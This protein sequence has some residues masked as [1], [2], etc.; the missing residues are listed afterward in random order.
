[1]KHGVAFS[2]SIRTEKIKHYRFPDGKES[3]MRGKVLL[4][5]L[6]IVSCIIFLKIVSLQLVRG[7]YYRTLSD[8]NR[9]RTKIIYAP[10]GVLFDR[11]NIPLVYNLP[12]FRVTKGNKTEVMSREKALEQISQ[13]AQNI[14][15]DSLRQYPFKDI[16]SHVLGYVGQITQEE[17]E[18]SDFN[19]YQT[20][21]LIGKS[22]IEY[23]YEKLLRGTNGKQLL[24]VDATGKEVRVL[25]QTDPISGQD[26]HLTLDSKLQQ[27]AYNAMKDVSRGALIISTPKGEILSIIS[28]PSF[29]PNLFTL[30]SSYTATNTAYPSISGI[31]TGVD[32][33]LLDRAISGTYPPGSTFKVVMAAGALQSKK[34]DTSYEVDDQGKIQIGPYTYSN[35]YYTDYGKT[36]GKI[37]VV[38]A[39]TR[40][41]DIFFYELAAKM[42]LSTLVSSARQMGVGKALGID[43]PGEAHGV[44]P[45]EAWKKKN[46]GEDWYLG[47][48][49]IYGIG[50]GYLLTT[51]L[52]VNAWTQIIAN[53]GDLYQPH[54]LENMGDRII[55]NNVLSSGTV[56]SVRKGMIGACDPGG[57]AWPLFDFKVKNPDL[58]VDNKNIIQSASNGAEMKHV[59]IA[60]KTGTAQHGGDTTPPDAWLTLFAPAYDPQIVVTVLKEDS[61][62][63]SNEAGPI[64]AKILDSYFG[65]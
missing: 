52:Q 46:V 60:C 1:M 50:Q 16:F 32:Q 10:R 51:P 43:L 29:D 28:K 7:E 17:H 58:K 3:S 9:I 31:L 40:S 61:G 39:L 57:T 41:D 33:P 34:I 21:D 42:G 19:D 2:D 64:A 59:V 37:S 27:A 15:V 25:G 47:D 45:D 44:L 62:E 5:T 24:E 22:G 36:E 11:N 13:G 18:S 48:T 26:L 23:Q 63:G 56:D 14:S 53:G 49:Y 6:C 12:G 4:V 54:I 8:S 30:G 65:K 55:T 35:W 38:R 20:T